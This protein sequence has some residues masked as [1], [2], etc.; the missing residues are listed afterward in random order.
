MPLRVNTAL[1]AVTYSLPNMYN[2]DI[3][4]G[5]LWTGQKWVV[6]NKRMASYSDVTWPRGSRI[7]YE[8]YYCLD[9]TTTNSRAF[10]LVLDDLGFSK[11]YFV[12]RRPT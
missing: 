2:E 12:S 7:S 3:G 4:E 10:G 1:D 8:Y 6:G 5:K 9:V 11:P